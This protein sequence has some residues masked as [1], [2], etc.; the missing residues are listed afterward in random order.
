MKTRCVL[1]TLVIYQKREFLNY[2]I[3]NF[4]KLFSC[5]EIVIDLII[6]VHLNKRL[7]ARAWINFSTAFPPQ[8]PCL[9]LPCFPPPSLSISLEILLPPCLLLLLKV[10]SFSLSLS[11]SPS[12]LILQEK[13][14]ISNIHFNFSY[15]FTNLLLNSSRFLNPLIEYSV[16][17][18]AVTY[19]LFS[20]IWKRLWP[21][22][23]PG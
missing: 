19:F 11:L 17:T 12:F 4:N 20:K 5:F 9:S 1:Y 10:T 18:S 15:Q 2:T 22:T 3:L 14:V 8:F 13:D 21:N 23:Q 7:T 6:K 16:L